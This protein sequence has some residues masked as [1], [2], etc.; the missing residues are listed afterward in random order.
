MVNKRKVRLMTRTALYEKHECSE[1]IPKAKYYKTDYVG[2]HMW[3]T[4]VAVTAAYFIIL[5][6]AAA[7]NFEYIVNN[8]TKMNY[9][10]LVLLL[11]TV[12]ATMMVLFLLIAYFVYSYK[13]TEA[14][15][16]IKVYQSRLHKIFLMNKEDR[17][18]K[19]GLPK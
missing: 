19:G 11:V 15:N 14:E 12:Y 5:L 6:L 3:T 13:Y 10:L 7:Y 1:D 18:R 16:G 17:K 4:A 9:T 2:L 8:L